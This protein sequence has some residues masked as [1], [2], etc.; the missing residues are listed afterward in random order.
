[1][2]DLSLKRAYPMYYRNCQKKI[3]TFARSSA[4]S[5][6]FAEENQ[7]REQCKRFNPPRQN[8]RIIGGKKK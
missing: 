1:M 8:N 4:S 3:T 5:L 6:T 2:L 7:K